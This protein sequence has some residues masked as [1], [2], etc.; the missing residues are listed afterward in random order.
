MKSIKSIKIN[1]DGYPTIVSDIYQD[2]AN[3]EGGKCEGTKKA[4][5]PLIETMNALMP[6]VREVCNLGDKWID[7]LGTFARVSGVVLKDDG[8]VITA[9]LQHDY[10]DTVKTAIANTPY[11][12][13]KYLQ[14]HEEMQ[15]EAL[16]REVNAYLD[17]LPVQTDMF[18]Q[19]TV[20]A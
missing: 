2:G 19:E 4:G 20:T 6:I 18:T 12:E 13:N 14:T 11:I 5:E 15:L 9:Q 7:T 8:I 1:A 3:F 17:S 10:G 16:K